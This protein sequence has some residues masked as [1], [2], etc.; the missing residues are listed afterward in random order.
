METKRKKEIMASIQR[1][2]AAAKSTGDDKRLGMVA[3]RKKVSL[4]EVKVRAYSGGC[5]VET[6]TNGDGKAGRR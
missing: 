4:P 1:N 5:G 6:R 2:V 3:S